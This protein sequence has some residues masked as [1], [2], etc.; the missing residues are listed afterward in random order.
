MIALAQWH[1]ASGTEAIVVTG[2]TGEGITLQA[3]E[4]AEILSVV[5]HTVAGKI[6]VWMGT[7]TACTAQTI[8]HTQAAANSLG[9]VWSHA[10]SLAAGG[11]QSPH[12]ASRSPGNHLSECSLCST[13]PP[14]Q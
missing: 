6:P 9:G 3:P 13:P 1:V 7:G 11:R 5:R 14:M 12:F 8:A 10:P 4:R 2:T